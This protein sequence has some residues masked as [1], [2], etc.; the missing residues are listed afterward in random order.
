MEGSDHCRPVLVKFGKCELVNAV[1]KWSY[2]QLN[3]DRQKN[4]LMD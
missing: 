3:D 4:E 1:M 2:I